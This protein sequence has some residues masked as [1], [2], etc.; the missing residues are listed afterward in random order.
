M[1]SLFA[2]VLMVECKDQR[3]FQTL[4]LEENL[5]SEEFERGAPL[6]ESYRKRKERSVESEERAL[7]PLASAGVSLSV[8]HLCC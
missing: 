5:K 8:R 2:S 6:P 1:R 3:S 4:E 7:A